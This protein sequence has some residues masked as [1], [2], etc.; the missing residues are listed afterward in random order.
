MSNYEYAQATDDDLNEW[1]W[2][3]CQDEQNAAYEER[4][5]NYYAARGLSNIY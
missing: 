2:R 1:G 4:V 3:A 5:Y